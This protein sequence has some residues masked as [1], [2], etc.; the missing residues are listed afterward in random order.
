MKFGNRW[1]ICLRRWRQPESVA[2]CAFLENNRP[3]DVGCI[4]P[5]WR[6]ANQNISD[7]RRAEGRYIGFS[8]GH[9]CRRPVSGVVPPVINRIQVPS[10]AAGL[11]CTRAGYNSNDDCESIDLQANLQVH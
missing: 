2:P 7:A 8:V 3:D 11:R 10:R 5:I 1:K 6:I 4:I 9:G